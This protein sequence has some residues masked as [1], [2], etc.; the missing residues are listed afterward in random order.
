MFVQFWKLF[1]IQP[2]LCRS[3]YVWSIFTN[4]TN[5][6]IQKK[7]ADGFSLWLK[8][9]PTN[10]QQLVPYL[11]ETFACISNMV[12][13]PDDNED[14]EYKGVQ[15]HA[16]AIV[17]GVSTAGMFDQTQKFSTTICP[18]AYNVLEHLTKHT[19]TLETVDAYT[20]AC[21]ATFRKDVVCGLFRCAPHSGTVRVPNALAVISFFLVGDYPAGVKQ[22]AKSAMQS[23]SNINKECLQ[24]S[25]AEIM[26]IIKTGE[27]DDLIFNF[28]TMP[29]LYTRTPSAVH[30]NL[31]MI[32][33]RFNWMQVCS[34]VNNVASRSPAHLVP[35]VNT[36][37]GKMTEAPAMGA[38][39]LGCLKEIGKVNP[40]AIYD[41]IEA[42][43]AAGRNIQGASYAVAGCI[44]AAAKSKTKTNAGDIMLEHMM[45]CVKNC[46]AMYRAAVMAELVDIRDALSSPQA[47]APHMDYLKTLKGTHSIQVQTLE[48]YFAGY[49]T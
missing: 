34:L 37:M 29:E 46:E 47:L 48:D 43:I 20:T 23:M 3:G 40:D 16:A 38:I 11:E 17:E 13:Q 10:G 9:A 41:Y 6:F 35:Y 8:S 5:A 4:V 25:G 31:D 27:H 44:G 42:I 21:A 24:D 1:K 26:E 30:D 18:L 15:S 33:T 14:G 12:T 19:F 45:A 28:L 2:T 22:A 39:T 32:M 36:L 7:I 49:V